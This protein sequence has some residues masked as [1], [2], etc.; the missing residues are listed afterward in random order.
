MPQYKASIIDR[1]IVE[2]PE[3]RGES[4]PL[5]AFGE[6]E[7]RESVRRDLEWL[8]NTR[9]SD[10]R[11]LLDKRELTV[12][13]YGVPDFGDYFITGTADQQRLEKN[14]TRAITAFEPRI[15]GVKVSIRQVG[16]DDVRDDIPLEKTLRVIVE[17]VIN[18]LIKVEKGRDPISFSTILEAKSGIGE[19]RER[20]PDN[21]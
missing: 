3:S 11:S 14:L 16:P 1:L 6:E 9:S 18:G 5:R 7:F 17:V 15:Q 20:E 4:V 10:P 8:L 12:L 13:D 2:E 21:P 19:L